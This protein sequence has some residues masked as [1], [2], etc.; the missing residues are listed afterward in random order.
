MKSLFSALLVLAVPALSG[1][2]PLGNFTTNRYAALTVEP[3]AVRVAYVVDLAELPAYREIEVVDMD[4]NGTIDAAERDA[5]RLRLDGERGVPVGGEVSQRVGA[6][7]RRDGQHEQRG[8]QVLHRASR[9]SARAR[10][11][12]S[13]ASSVARAVGP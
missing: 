1:A 8:E 13:S 3:Q 2:H 7:E 12:F 4:G 10:R 9:P 5:H 6:G 11:G